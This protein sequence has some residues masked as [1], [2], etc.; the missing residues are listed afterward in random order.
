M[1]PRN[2]PASLILFAYNQE[3]YIESA[4]HSALS[5]NYEPLEILI[6][7]D[8][9]SD[10][11]FSLIEKITKDYSGRHSVKI[12]RNEQNLGLIEHINKAFSM[13]TGEIIAVAAGDDIS[14]PDRVN[15]IVEAYLQ[16][17]ERPTLVHSSAIQIDHQDIEAGE[18]KPEWG[19][20][21]P[22]IAHSALS[23]AL[24]IGATAAY[25]RSLLALFPPIQNKRTYEDL[26]WGFRS[27]LVKAVVY[28]DK[29]LVK[30]RTNVGIS[31]KL[32]EGKSPQEKK[33]SR[34]NK[35]RLYREVLK[36]RVCDSQSIDYPNKAT[37]E[38]K[39][40]REMLKTSIQISLLETPL[41]SLIYLAI[42]PRIYLR[43]RK[44]LTS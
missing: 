16:N 33:A 19:I 26:V 13:V 28:I 14:L 8:C 18:I 32:H 5:Q 43:Q 4:V 35:L 21:E 41:K 24:Y 27:A 17:N 9:S 42:H 12:N 29:P 39:L 38:K 44:K 25:S 31:W 20:S 22:Q 40:H 6:S 30:Y 23:P 2:I 3:D 7:D 37:I 10:K 36:Q 1:K 34:L 15:Q 11:T